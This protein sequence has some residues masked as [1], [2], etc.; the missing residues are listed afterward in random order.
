VLTVRAAAQ[1]T[2]TTSTLIIGITAPR[3]LPPD[4][5][6]HDAVHLD[7]TAALR[8]GIPPFH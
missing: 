4:N 7:L 5:A 1:T 2:L 3:D 8:S 6:V